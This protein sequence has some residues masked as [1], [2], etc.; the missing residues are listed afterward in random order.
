MIT[1]TM[2]WNEVNSYFCKIHQQLFSNKQFLKL[3]RQKR[4]N[5]FKKPED[6]F[7]FNGLDSIDLKDNNKVYIFYYMPS[8]TC[9]KLFILFSIFS[10][11]KKDYVAFFVA[12]E[13]KPDY[14]II[15]SW[16]ALDR[17][18]ERF[19]DEKNAIINAE[20]IA[21]LLV[22]NAV[23]VI[24]N[25]TDKNRDN[26]NRYFITSDGV[27]MGE[28][29]DGYYIIHTFVTREMLFRSQKYVDKEGMQEIRNYIQAKYKLAV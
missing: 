7:I 9:E 27:F 23:A 11:R 2:T 24:F 3:M 15:Y 16:H 19:Y 18:F 22:Y 13:D 8:Q 12:R 4:Y 29:G 26:S 6:G 14:V 20:D 1:D 5:R 17:Y 10:Y 25:G 28:E 21:K